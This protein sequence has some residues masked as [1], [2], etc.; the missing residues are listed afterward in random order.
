MQVGDVVLIIEAGGLLAE[1]ALVEIIRAGHPV[2]GHGMQFRLLAGKTSKSYSCCRVP[3][4]GL[5]GRN[6]T[7]K[8]TF[9]MPG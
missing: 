3:Y 1:I 6:L 5:F 9:L 8:A 2:T 7:G 4:T